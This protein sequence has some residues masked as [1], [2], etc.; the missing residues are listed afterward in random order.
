MLAA[1]MTVPATSATPRLP[2]RPARPG[3]ARP[4]GLGAMLGHLDPP[5]HR[6]RTYT[7]SEKE[8]VF[9]RCFFDK[10][11]KGQYRIRIDRAKM[12]ENE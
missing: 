9:E 2:P 3:E 1:R 11:E 7:N 8:R 4:G 12:S 5:Q 6:R 10:G